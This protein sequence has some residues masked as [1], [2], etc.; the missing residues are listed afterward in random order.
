MLRRAFW[1]FAYCCNRRCLLWHD[2]LELKRANIGLARFLPALL[3]RQFR[4][5]PKSKGAGA[6][7]KQAR[8]VN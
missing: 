8:T 2:K 7:A 6:Q 5:T 3:L 4:E 1:P